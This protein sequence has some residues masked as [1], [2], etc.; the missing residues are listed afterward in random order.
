M[1][2]CRLVKCASLLFLLSVTSLSHGTTR[3]QPSIYPFWVEGH[4]AIGIGNGMVI[5]KTQDMGEEALVFYVSRSLNIKDSCSWDLEGTRFT[6]T[7]GLLLVTPTRIAYRCDAK[8]FDT[9]RTDV[10]VKVEASVHAALGFFYASQKEWHAAFEVHTH[11]DKYT[12]FGARMT[13]PGV[14]ESEYPA[15]ES[16]REDYITYRN[17]EWAKWAK[18]AIEDFPTALQTFNEVVRPLRE[19]LAAEKAKEESLA[20][21]NAALLQSNT[22]RNAGD[23][24]AAVGN[25]REALQHYLAAIQSMPEDPPADIDESLRERIVK[26]VAQ[27]N[28][29]PALPEDAIRHAAYAQAALEKSKESGNNVHL[30]NA[31]REWQQSLRIAPWWADCYFNL[32]AALKTAHR[33]GEAAQ[34]LNLYLLANPNAQNAQDVKME[35]Y[36]LEYEAKNP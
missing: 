3:T 22:Q 16:E 26:L 1:T 30:D 20:Q 28:P 7:A 31:I 11:R 27:L 33:P 29:P 17:E 21:R 24:A 13:F 35:I 18:L 8:G 32:G 23:E 19:Q 36:K 6:S 25:L 15:D 4:P 5:L 2:T 14:R 10:Q 9:L 12:L 34:A